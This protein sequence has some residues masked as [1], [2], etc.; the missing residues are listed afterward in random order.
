MYENS[1]LLTVVQASCLPGMSNKDLS[2]P[3]VSAALCPLTMFPVT[4]QHRTRT[5]AGTVN[6]V[7]NETFLL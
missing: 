1:F 3:F 2:S 7:Y 5:E 4:K 6:P